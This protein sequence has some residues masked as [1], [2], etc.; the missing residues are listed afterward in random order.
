M[1]IEI[2]SIGKGNEAYIESGIQV[3]AERLKPLVSVRLQILSL[4]RKLQTSDRQ[5]QIQAE[6]NLILSKLDDRA[7]LILFDERGKSYTSVQ[8]SH[9][10]QSLT[11]QGIQKLVFLIGGAYGVGPKLRAKA[12][13]S[14]S[15]SSLV[16]PHQLVRLM[17]YEQLYRAY[18]I[19]HHLPYHHD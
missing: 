17:V 14:W 19:L 6:E 15:L 9:Q 18:S 7:Y 10:I 13:Q 11:N 5:Q 4:P 12:R 8:W 16:F 1:K 3:Y 2:W